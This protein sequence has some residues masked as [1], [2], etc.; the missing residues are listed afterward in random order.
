MVSKNE[1]CEMKVVFGNDLNIWTHVLRE[2]V[3]KSNYS[4]FCGQYQQLFNS[5]FY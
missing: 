2:E 5:E 1:R 4:I 3:L